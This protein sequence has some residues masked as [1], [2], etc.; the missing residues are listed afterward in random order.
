MSSGK[1]DN[2]NTQGD[3]W[4]HTLNCLTFVGA[5]V[6]GAYCKELI[7]TTAASAQ[8]GANS[9]L[10]AL[11]PFNNCPN[12]NGQMNSSSD[13]SSLG[14]SSTF[15]QNSKTAPTYTMQELDDLK[16]R[17]EKENS[18]AALNRDFQRQRWLVD[19]L[20]LLENIIHKRNEMMQRQQS[21]DFSRSSSEL[22][23]LHQDLFTRLEEESDKATGAATSECEQD[24]TPGVLQ[25]VQAT[26]GFGRGA[27]TGGAI[28]DKKS[29][30]SRAI[31]VTPTKKSPSAKKKQSSK[32]SISSCNSLSMKQ[33]PFNIPDIEEQDADESTVIAPVAPV[34]LDKKRPADDSLMPQEISGAN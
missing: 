5:A 6:V 15:R 30:A 8:P 19:T 25:R 1:R 33:V 32:R 21:G 11:N 34:L 4:N 14:A 9:G 23:S 17:Y 12:L 2:K 18:Q 26:F 29:H 13:N 3:G 22:E 20:E 16:A 31:K 24:E 27:T 10:W 28:Q 7:N